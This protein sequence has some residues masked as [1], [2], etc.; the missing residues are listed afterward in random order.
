MR[1]RRVMDSLGTAVLVAALAWFVWHGIG[2]IVAA[3]AQQATSSTAPAAQSAPT[4]TAAPAPQ[5]G[6]PQMPTGPV[7]RSVSRLVRVDVVVTDKKG[8]YVKDLTTNDFK[9]YE[10]NKQMS[11]STFSFGN[12]PAAPAGTQRH[13]LI[14]FFDNSTMDFSDQGRARE[15]AAKFIDAN[16]GPDRVMAVADFGG[17]VRITQNFTMDV[18]KLKAAV[19]ALKGSAVAPN[20]PVTDVMPSGEPALGNVEADF[21]ARSVLL[22]IRSLARELAD[23]PG[24]KTLILFTSGFPLTPEITS[25]LT[26]TIDACNKANVAIYP[27]DVRGLVAGISAAPG[28]ATLREGNPS[29]KDA[30]YAANSARTDVPNYRPQIVQA[31]FHPDPAAAP[32]H[33]GGNGGVGGGGGG[34]GGKGGGGGTGGG[35]SGGGGKGGTGGTG[36][37]GSSGGGKGGGGGAP[38]SSFG[39]TMYTQPRSI[40]PIFPPSTS[41]NQQVLFA[42]A[43]GT[44]GFPIF[45]SNDLLAGLEKIRRDQDEYYLLGYA[46]ENSREGTCHTLKVKVERGGSNVRAR[47]GYCNTKPVDALAGDPLEKSLE[48]RALSATPA[49]TDGSVE[50]PFFY[51]GPNEARVDLAMDVPSTSVQFSKEKGKY[52]TEIN[53]LGIAARPDGEVAARF[54]DTVP[55]DFEKDGMK[56][57]T[58]TPWHYQNQ[59]AVAPGEFKLTVVLS[60]GDKFIGK[61]ETPLAI[62][63][64]DG[65]KLSLSGVV[66]SDEV[67]RIADAGVGLDSEL[68]EDHTPLLVK[69]MQVIPSGSDKF[70]KDDKVVMYA[71]IYEPRLVDTTPPAVRFAYRVVDTKSGTVMMS[72][73]LMD[74]GTYIE[75]GNPMIPV[76]L[77]VP[78]DDLKPGPYRLDMQALEPGGATSQIRSINFDVE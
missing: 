15:A 17:A 71:Q 11:V 57:F 3:N 31:A 1:L 54:S 48:A 55:L 35:G 12:D 16:A 21:G 37:S 75:K 38:I 41:T 10:D 67:S 58:K 19:G 27:L 61:Y 36:G 24:R 28:G 26:A 62:D 49:N 72:T 45:N 39:N 78:L 59:F 46:P 77:K 42:L 63:K 60:A 52:R 53:I 50:A 7:I 40:V 34:G 74:A 30:L 76:A 23:I 33:G 69:G 20:A 22:G 8:N 51:T 6:Q 68:L 66:L 14:L 13:Y 9:V 64:Y 65:K 25:E 2:F 29:S 5:Q 44:G 43:D 70:K 4:T 32:Q 73:G 47:S 18:S 56:E